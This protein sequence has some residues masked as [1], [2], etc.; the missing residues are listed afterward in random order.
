M[1]KTASAAQSPTGSSAPVD[2]FIEQMGL[3]AQMENLPRIAGRIFGLFLVEG[4]PLNLREVAE[5][6][7]VSRAS[8]STNARILTQ[9]GLLERSAK[10][11]DRQDYYQLSPDPYRNLVTGMVQKMTLAHQIVARA[12]D[13]FPSDRPEAKRRVGEMALFYQ[14]TA[15][16]IAEVSERC[17]A[18]WDAATPA[19][20]DSQPTRSKKRGT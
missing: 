9:L 17:A 2:R 15:E 19:G 18:L 4:G 5:R 14:I 10:P 16:T 1:T 20:D 6:L 12:A 7:R 8:I 11:G 13:D 3:V